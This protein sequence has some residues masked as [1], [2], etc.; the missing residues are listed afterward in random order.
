MKLSIIG[1]TANPTEKQYAWKEAL[2]SYVDQADE[3][4]IIN[5]GT[6]FLNTEGVT[7]I[8]KPDP[9]IW[10]W[11]EHAKNLNMALDVATGDWIIKIDLDWVFHDKDMARLRRRLGSS[12]AQNFMVATMQ[13]KTYYPVGRYVQKGRIPIIINKNDKERVRFGRD[14]DNYTDLTYPIRVNPN[15]P[16]L[17]E[18]KVPVGKLLMEDEWAKTGIEFWNFDYT[19]STYENMKKK[20][21]R[22]SKSHRVYF[23][24]TLWGD[25][26]EEAEQLF[27]K[28]MRG[29]IAKSFPVDVEELP[30]YIRERITNIKPEEFGFNGWGLL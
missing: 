26:E 29:K 3:V 21:M 6:E 9:P 2:A 22:M 12:E 1:L 8:M 5:G 4:I 19:F 24:N 11:A 18:H 20:W 15:R 30:K 13:K 10:N 25:T 7:E 14:Y 23:G 28:N 27:L 17:D 16:V